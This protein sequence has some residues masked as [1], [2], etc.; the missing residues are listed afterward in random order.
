MYASMALV[1]AKPNSVPVAQHGSVTTSVLQA[2]GCNI[3]AENSRD[4][5]AAVELCGFYLD[6]RVLRRS[7]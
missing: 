1:V 6:A 3:E 2:A 4:D 7:L 5:E